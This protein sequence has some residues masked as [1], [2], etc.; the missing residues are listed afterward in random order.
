M[1]ERLRSLATQ[2]ARL[3]VDPWKPVTSALAVLA[4][5]LA[6][7]AAHATPVIAKACPGQKAG[8]SPYLTTKGRQVSYRSRSL[9]A[10]WDTFCAFHGSDYARDKSHVFFRGRT[11]PRADAGTFVLAHRFVGKDKQRVYLLGWPAAVEDVRTFQVLGSMMRDSSRL[12]AKD[13]RAVY[14][15]K[16]PSGKVSAPITLKKVRHADPATFRILVYDGD[17]SYYAKDRQRVYFF[18]VQSDEHFELVKGAHA[19]SF[20]VMGCRESWG[21]WGKDRRRVFEKRRWLRFVDAGSFSFIGLH[22]A[23]D[24]RHVYRRA[25]WKVIK[26]ADPRTFHSTRGRGVDAVDR[27]YQ[28]NGG[29]RLR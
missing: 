5:L 29:R 22:Y 4:L 18:D 1:H 14:C 8:W 2:P 11:I 16:A 17:P 27:R 25:G 6:S 20:R 9:T 13:G 21:Y 19:K 12:V 28:Y 15:F 3:A 23:K 24:K 7:T 26:G 10:D